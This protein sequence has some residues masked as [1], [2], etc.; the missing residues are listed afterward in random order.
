MDEQLK[1]QMINKIK[2]CC[3]KATYYLIISAFQLIHKSIFG[4]WHPDG[5]KYK[6]R[7]V[8]RS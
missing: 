3:D 2:F 4:F 6:D 8:E 7:N 1:N 5:I